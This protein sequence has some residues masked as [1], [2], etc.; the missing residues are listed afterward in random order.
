MK[1]KNLKIVSFFL[2]NVGFF[3]PEV[4]ACMHACA[5]SQWLWQ[6]AGV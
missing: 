1:F 6:I 2:K 3:S 4:R 5:H